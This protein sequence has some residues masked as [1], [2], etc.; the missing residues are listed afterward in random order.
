MRAPEI[1]LG[2]LGILWRTNKRGDSRLADR[3][4]IEDTQLLL[5]RKCYFCCTKETTLYKPWQVK[6]CKQLALIIYRFHL[7]VHQLLTQGQTTTLLTHVVNLELQ[8]NLTRACVWDVTLA[9]RLE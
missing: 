2:T 3:A 7:S 6:Y 1:N 8:I 9:T 4:I 5:L